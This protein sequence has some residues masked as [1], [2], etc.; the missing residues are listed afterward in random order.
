MVWG[1]VQEAHYGGNMD[2]SKIASL[3]VGS[4]REEEEGTKV[5]QIPLRTCPQ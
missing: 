3:V 5:P 4:E 1:F 2:I